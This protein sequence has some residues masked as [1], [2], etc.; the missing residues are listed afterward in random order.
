MRT[1]NRALRGSVVGVALLGA[2]M[3]LTP[4]SVAR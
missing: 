1:Y 2:L 3:G 4:L